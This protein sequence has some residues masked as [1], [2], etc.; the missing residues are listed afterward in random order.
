ML[1]FQNPGVKGGARKVRDASVFFVTQKGMFLCRGLGTD[2]VRAAG[3]E[4]KLRQGERMALPGGLAD[5][6]DVKDGRLSTGGLR[7]PR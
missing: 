4:F 5:G 2:L 7:V 6:F 3:F 1:E